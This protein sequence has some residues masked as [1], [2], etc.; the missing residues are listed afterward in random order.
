[1]VSYHGVPCTM[2]LCSHVFWHT[3]HITLLACCFAQCFRQRLLRLLALCENRT[4]AQCK[5]W[6]SYNEKDPFQ[7]P[8]TVLHCESEQI[9]S[10]SLSLHCVMVSFHF[11]WISCA[12]IT[13]EKQALQ[14]LLSNTR[15]FCS[16][17]GAALGVNVFMIWYD[18]CL[19][20]KQW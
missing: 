6:C 7:I 1:M 11:T 2:Q 9:T 3:H 13:S 14:I 19:P 12:C 5:L 16:P 20:S 18:F 17:T 15:R 4:L 8:I 10:E